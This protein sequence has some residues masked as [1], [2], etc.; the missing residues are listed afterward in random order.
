MDKGA[1][2]KITWEFDTI[3]NSDRFETIDTRE[4]H[5]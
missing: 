2:L 1:S 4:T 5:Q 3:L